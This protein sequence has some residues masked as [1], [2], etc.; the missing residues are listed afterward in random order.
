VSA[1]RTKKIHDHVAL[2]SDVKLVFRYDGVCMNMA[3]RKY[4]SD[5]SQEMNNPIHRARELRQSIWYDDLHRG[6]LTSGR[7]A[8][9]VDSEGVAGVTCKPSVLEKAI[10][11]GKCYDAAIRELLQQRVNKASSIYE[12]LIVADIRSAADAL[13]P[14]YGRTW[15]TDGY[16]NLEVSPEL[17]QDTAEMVR[18]ARRLDRAVHRRNL[19]I[20]IPA[21]APGVQAVERLVAEGIN[22]NATLIF[23]VDVYLD[24]VQAY[25]KGLE[26][27][28]AQG[29]DPGNV[30]SVASFF[31]NRI[32]TAV[33]LRLKEK[34]DAAPDL[35]NGERLHD[36]FGQAAI[37]S[38]K[39]AYEKY[40]GLILTPRWRALER[41]GARPQR[42][43]WGGTAT[44]N[45]AYGTTRYVDELI[46]P[47]TVSTMPEGTYLEFLQHGQPRLSLTSGVSEAREILNRIAEAGISMKDVADKLLQV[48]VRSFTEA[49]QGMLAAIERKRQIFS[50][51]VMTPAR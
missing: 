18:E 16:V 39:I 44:K 13:R 41:K 32:D 1:A 49:H 35:S 48:G 25:M 45:L 11:V 51:A 42:L 47:E 26:R 24:V 4:E 2:A 15:A 23:S 20:K 28:A 33:D 38:A 17:A 22:V 37:A 43:S 5:L 29:G 31:I 34:V 30:S 12:R 9:M 40:Q 6:L 27:F 7:L 19:M 3:A 46:G 8:R 14:V 50:A 36:L 21:T 10:V